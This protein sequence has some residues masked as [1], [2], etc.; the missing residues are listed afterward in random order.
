MPQIVLDKLAGVNGT[1]A[2]LNLPPGEASV[3]Q[4]VRNRPLTNWVKRKGVEP[5]ET[6]S[7]PYMGIFDIELDGIVIPIIQAGGTLT[8][9]PNLESESFPNPDPRPVF[10]PIDGGGNG[11]VLFLIEPLMRSLQE[12][13]L[14]VGLTKKTWPNG[15]ITTSTT[16][17]VFFNPD[18]TLINGTTGVLL[19]DIAAWNQNVVDY[20]PAGSGTAAFPTNNIY[21]HDLYY[22]D[23]YLGQ[24]VGTRASQLI[25]VIRTA[26]LDL[27]A[28]N[29]Y[30]ADPEGQSSIPYCDSSNTGVPSASTKA[31][32]RSTL[33]NLRNAFRLVFRAVKIC[34]LRNDANTADGNENREGNNG[35]A[36]DPSCAAAKADAITQWNSASWGAG[37]AFTGLRLNEGTADDGAGGYTA[38]LYSSRGKLKSDLTNYT[39]TLGKF[40]IL[41]TAYPNGLSNQASAPV[42]VDSTF[43]EYE[44]FST[45][46]VA[47]SST[48]ASIIP[49][50]TSTCPVQVSNDSKGWS[51]NVVL[52]SSAIATFN[53]TFTNF[54]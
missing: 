9:Y 35:G 43:H 8:F 33:T 29:K 38:A 27:L 30:V 18:G 6:S 51:S 32:Y 23:A 19:T 42:T 48:I 26:I 7:N 31:N 12:K 21:K 28:E 13:R 46:G 39:G 52:G 34:T 25:N 45:G 14:R 50:F 41:C 44:S 36:A 17:N 15:N 47:L 53:V 5:L 3:S 24:A 4:N 49:T 20:W 10:N 40:Y 22:M 1:T 54:F 2:E 37:A 11:A 16:T